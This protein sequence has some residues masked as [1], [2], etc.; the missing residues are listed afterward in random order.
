MIKDFLIIKCIGNDDKLGLR[1]N[2]DFFFT[3]SKIKTIVK[4]SLPKFLIASKNTK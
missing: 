1:I 4:S 2:K 3:N